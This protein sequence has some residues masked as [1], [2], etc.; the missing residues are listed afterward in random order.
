MNKLDQLI[1]IISAMLPL[2]TGMYTLEDI[3]KDWHNEH[4]SK[5]YPDH[6]NIDCLISECHL[7]QERV[8]RRVLLKCEAFPCLVIE[9]LSL[10]GKNAIFKQ[11]TYTLVI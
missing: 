7:V 11:A 6:V 2:K 10:I 9:P 1:H 4:F 8:E 3:K 5:R